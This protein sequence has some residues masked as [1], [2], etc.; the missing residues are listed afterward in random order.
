MLRRWSRVLA[1]QIGCSQP[2][3]RHPERDVLDDPA[4]QA[5]VGEQKVFRVDDRGP[6]GDADHEHRQLEQ[7]LEHLGPLGPGLLPCRWLEDLAKAGSVDPVDEGVAG[8]G[9]DE[10]LVVSVKGDLFECRGEIC[11][12]LACER[13]S[14]AHR[15]DRAASGRRCKARVRRRL[16]GVREDSRL[17]PMGYEIVALFVFTWKGAAIV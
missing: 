11:M 16:L 3:E 15:R 6:V 9:D 10:C 1:G 8:P 4:A 17:Q 14:A 5:D 2:F 13:G 12:R 7:T